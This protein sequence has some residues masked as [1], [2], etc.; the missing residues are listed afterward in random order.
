MLEFGEDLDDFTKYPYTSIKARIYIEFAAILIRLLTR[1]HITPNMLTY[2]YAALGPISIILTLKNSDLSLFLAVINFV[3]IKGILDWS[4][5]ALARITNKSSKL[6]E[7]L[8]AWGAH[9]NT[10]CFVLSIGIYLYKNTNSSIFLYLLLFVALLKA[11]DLKDFKYYLIGKYDLEKKLTNEKLENSSYLKNST[12]ANS[13][14]FSVYK[15]STFI[16]DERARTVDGILAVMIVE[17]III[18]EL[19]FSQLIFYLFVIALLARFFGGIYL[20][21]KNQTI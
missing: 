15:L 21:Q 10:T 3:F 13:S 16:L 5:G 18:Q 17:N 1:T 11:I 9:V 20:V 2:T 6:G 14:L 4:D 7:V 8:D 12:S 19:V